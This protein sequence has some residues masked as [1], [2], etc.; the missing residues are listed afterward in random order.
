MEQDAGELKESVG[1]LNVQLKGVLEKMR[2]PGKLCLDMILMIVLAVVIG[3]LVA[4]VNYYMKMRAE[5]IT[6]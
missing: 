3:I 2:E 5:Q 6:V 1:D 4:A